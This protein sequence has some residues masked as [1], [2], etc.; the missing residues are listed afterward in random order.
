MVRLESSRDYIGAVD[1]PETGELIQ[2]DA[3]H[4]RETAETVADAYAFL[5]VSGET[6]GAD[7]DESEAD[8]AESTESE[9][10]ECGVNGCSRDVDGPDDTCWQ[11]P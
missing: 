11:H 6:D 5:S 1:H 8:A 3:D 9:A 2:L 4:S 7:A 10:Y